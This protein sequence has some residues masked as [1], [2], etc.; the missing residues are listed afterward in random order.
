[1]LPVNSEVCISYLRV[2]REH[3]LGMEYILP[4]LLC[5]GNI[6]AYFRVTSKHFEA[7]LTYL[8]L[9]YARGRGDTVGKAG[10]ME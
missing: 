1:M 6:S 2:Y 4:F 8:S 3:T 10:V 5:Y 9:E 7:A